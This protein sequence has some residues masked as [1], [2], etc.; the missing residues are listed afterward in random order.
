M[1]SIFKGLGLSS[2][3]IVSMA[4]FVLSC[5]KE[6]T[7]T[8]NEN[9][10]G[11][12]L[13][14]ESDVTLSDLGYVNDDGIFVSIT[15]SELEN[16]FVNHLGVSSSASFSHELMFDENDGYYFVR[17][18]TSGLSIGSK[19]EVVELEEGGFQ[20][21]FD[22]ETCQCSGN[23]SCTEGCEVTSMCACSD[24][25]YSGMCSKTH[26]VTVEEL[27]ASDFIVNI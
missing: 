9:T 6:S 13:Y 8:I 27:T 17:S 22:S 1:K 4:I 7:S 11:Q 26:T 16:Y 18:T 20:A 10:S 19:L 25:T 15:T 5:E 21:I 12:P 14:D 23:A 3:L 24:C 2:L